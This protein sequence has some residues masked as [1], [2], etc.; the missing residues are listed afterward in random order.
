MMREA[1]PIKMVVSDLDGTLLDESRFISDDAVRLIDHL[2]KQNIGFTFITGRPYTAVKKFET[3]ANITLP[4]VTCNGAEIIHG[5]NSI[6]QKSMPLEPLRNIMLTAMQMDSTVLFYH[7]GVEYAL[8][9]TPWVRERQHRGTP[10]P[11]P[12]LTKSFWATQ[13]AEKVTI[14]NDSLNAEFSSKLPVSRIAE[15]YTVCCYGNSGCE[16][17][18]K[19]MNKG[20][21]LKKLS[22][23]LGVC[24]DNILAIGDSENDIEMFQTA[25]VSAAVSNATD[26]AKQNADFICSRPRTNGV[27]EAITH[28][29]LIQR[30]TK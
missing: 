9:E 27:I 6:F 11:F 18:S 13:E 24:L 26:T 29:C 7:N 15:D 4:I 14:I 28:F 2:K 12:D 30:D 1:K 22:A 25:G 23:I 10:Y 8:S 21:G 17:T 20:E 3:R 16:I 19:G 5:G